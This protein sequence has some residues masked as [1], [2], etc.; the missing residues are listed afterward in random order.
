MK[1]KSVGTLSSACGGVFAAL[2]LLNFWLCLSAVA[3]AQPATDQTTEVCQDQTDGAQARTACP[4]ANLL[5][6]AWKKGSTVYY[7]ISALPSNEQAAVK[8]A[9][10]DW[11]TANASDG[12]GVTFAAATTQNPATYTWSNVPITPTG[13]SGACT[14]SSTAGAKTC[15][16]GTG[17]ATSSAV[18]VFNLS[19][20]ISGSTPLYSISAPNYSNFLVQVALHEIGHSMGLGDSGPT[21]NPTSCSNTTDN[22]VMNCAAGTNDVGNRIPNNVQNCDKTNVASNSSYGGGTKGGGGSGGS[23]LSTT[24]GTCKAAQPNE[25]CACENGTWVCDCA[26]SPPTCSDGTDSICYNDA[27]TCGT[28][29]VCTG[30]APTCSSGDEAE[31]IDDQWVC[32]DGCS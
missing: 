12:S 18:T 24:D 23:D 28:V 14:P 2:I 17:G 27:W 7:N 8:E 1:R 15:T 31:C 11:N 21:S 5:A 19:A 29:S 6:N 20:T 10:G 4:P 16:V 13:G 26:G 30:T 3:E 9:M 25:S 32:D 22:T